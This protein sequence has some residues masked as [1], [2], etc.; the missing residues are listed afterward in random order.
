[1]NNLSLERFRLTWGV[2][3]KKSAKI[4]LQSEMNSN[5]DKRRQTHRD[6]KDVREER[7][8]IDVK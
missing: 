1:M 5:T 3:K 2:L 4:K 7:V 8:M 6:A